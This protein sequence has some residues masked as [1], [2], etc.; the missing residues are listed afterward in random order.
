MTT[1]VSAVLLCA[2][3][4]AGRIS[5]G[6]RAGSECSVPNLPGNPRLDENRC[7]FYVGVMMF[8]QEKYGSASQIWK[9][10]MATEPMSS[11]NAWL[12]WAAQSNYAYLL[13]YGLGEK[14]QRDRA[15][16]L[17]REAAEHGVLEARTHLGFA[18]S[19]KSFNGYSLP[20]AYAWLTSYERRFQ[21]D[22]RGE[23]DDM[24]H[25][26]NKQL[27]AELKLKMTA[28]EISR[29]EILADQYSQANNED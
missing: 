2:A 20:V 3:C 9:R 27:L 14:T 4:G 5:G 13:Y 17:F 19:D 1:V 11:P 28:E 23:P 16:K 7:Q 25:K 22:K 10:V 21:K 8:R 29:G 18:Y 6:D 12:K 24:M 15:V 26:T